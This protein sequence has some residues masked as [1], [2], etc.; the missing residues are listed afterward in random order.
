MEGLF[1]IL[2][3]S[4]TK[5]STKAPGVG[6]SMLTPRQMCGTW[7]IHNQEVESGRA[8]VAENLAIYLA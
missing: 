7:R 5:L 4:L 2:L 3:Q 6:E 1:V 8:S